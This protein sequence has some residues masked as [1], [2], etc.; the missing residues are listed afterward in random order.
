MGKI[1]GVYFRNRAAVL[2]LW[3]GNQIVRSRI[4]VPEN[5]PQESVFSDEACFRHCF[6]RVF[7]ALLNQYYIRD[8]SFVLAVPDYYGI[9]EITRIYRM[10]EH[11]GISVKKCISVTAAAAM[12]ICFRGVCSEDF[13]VIHADGDKPGIGDYSFASG[14]IEKEYTYIP[15]VRYFKKSGRLLCLNTQNQFPLDERTVLNVYG[16]GNTDLIAMIAGSMRMLLKRA[17]PQKTDWS[18]WNI[19]MI[20]ED[21]PADGLAVMCGKLEGRKEVS[22]LLLLDTL[23]PYPVFAEAGGE[24]YEILPFETTI[25]TCKSVELDAG[26]DEIQSVPAGAKILEKR[27]NRF[28]AQ[29]IISLSQQ[30]QKELETG[31]AGQKEYVS[32]GLDVASNKKTEVWIEGRNGVKK[33]FSLHLQNIR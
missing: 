31:N 20:P 22:D 19:C 32:L 11:S 1:A 5:S 14:V 8:C 10:A 23:T 6:G 26:T 30:D 4:E 17:I 28:F 13:R 9:S 33:N 29:G 12:D 7:G 18:D 21:S 25:P 15:D 16:M 27:G 2:S 3:E 24:I